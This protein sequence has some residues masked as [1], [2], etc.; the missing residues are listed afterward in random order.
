[1][2]LSF[3]RRDEQ[4]ALADMFEPFKDSVAWL[5]RELRDKVEERHQASYDRP[6]DD[7]LN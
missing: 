7:E 5:P 3:N 2:R 1:M 4:Q 6:A